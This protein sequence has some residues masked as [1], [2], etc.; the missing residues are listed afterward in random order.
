[1]SL[2]YETLTEAIIGFAFELYS[3]LSYSSFSEKRK[4]SSGALSINQIRPAER[5]PRQSV[6][7]YLCKFCEKKTKFLHV[8]QKQFFRENSV[9]FRGKKF[10]CGLSLSGIIQVSSFA[11]FLFRRSV[12]RF[13][14]RVKRLD[15]HIYFT[16]LHLN[17]RPVFWIIVPLRIQFLNLPALLLYPGKVF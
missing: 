1:M 10:G 13:T 4:S 14:S 8:K 5:D 16:D 7:H 12:L 3:T 11:S 9:S 15:Q 17:I 2:E 6:A